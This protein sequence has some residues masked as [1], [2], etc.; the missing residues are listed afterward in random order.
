M[1]QRALAKIL[2]VSAMAVSDAVKHGRLRFCVKPD[3]YGIP[4]I[5]DVELAKKEWAENGNYARAPHMAPQRAPTVG[6]ET[7]DAPAESG[8]MLDAATRDKHWKAK[9]S[10]L[11]YKEAVGE[12]IQAS[13]VRREWTETLSQCRTKL[14]ALPSQV[15]QAIPA[16]TLD[17]VVIVENLVR[18]ALED[19]VDS[20]A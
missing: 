20:D 3:E 2:G 5:A 10:E 4:K 12:L 8:S 1:S 16:L 13:E 14:L 7:T 11:K 17:D 15:R 18:Q 19:L 9:L 6:P